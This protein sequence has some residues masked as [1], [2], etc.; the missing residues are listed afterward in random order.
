MNKL[1]PSC[2][3]IVCNTAHILL[4]DLQRVS[5][6]PFISMI[7]EVADAVAMDNLKRVGV[8]GT[9]VTIKSKLYQKALGRFDIRSVEPKGIELRFLEGIIKRI[10]VGLASRKDKV[11]LL[12]IANRLMEQGAQGIILGCTELPLI[13]P[14]KQDFPVFDS[15]EILALALLKK[16]DIEGGNYV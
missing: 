12:S 6:A 1:Q 13:F 3:A 10:I 4:S 15:L 9:P 14:K 11:L 8:L 7:E 5:K 16:A 2:L